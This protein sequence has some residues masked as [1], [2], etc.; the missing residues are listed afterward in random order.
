[1]HLW[2]A[3]YAPGAVVIDGATTELAGTSQQPL[4]AALLAGQ[5]AVR[6]ISQADSAALLPNITVPQTTAAESAAVDESCLHVRGVL[7][8]ILGRAPPPILS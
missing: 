1:M 3:P 7:R 6:T 5:P 4:H 2:A 8:I